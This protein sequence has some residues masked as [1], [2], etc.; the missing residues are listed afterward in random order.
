MTEHT[1][2]KERIGTIGDIK[3]GFIIKAKFTN[4]KIFSAEGNFTDPQNYQLFYGATRDLID[5]TS[6]FSYSIHVSDRRFSF[7][8]GYDRVDTLFP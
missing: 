7:M 3:V 1:H 4:G 8:S 6:G 2:S 5:D